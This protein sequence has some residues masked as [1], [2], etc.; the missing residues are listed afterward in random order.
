ML[1]PG[2]LDLLSETLGGPVGLWRPVLV[3]IVV[4]KLSHK[5]VFLVTV[6]LFMSLL[7][8]FIGG[9]NFFFEVVAYFFS[10]LNYF[11]LVRLNFLWVLRMNFF[12]RTANY[13]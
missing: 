6:L 2:N 11:N 10:S 12:T 3:K 13:F 7:C 5:S 4:I 1:F 8:I 9:T